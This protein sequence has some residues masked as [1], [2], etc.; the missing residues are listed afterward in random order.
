MMFGRKSLS[1]RSIG[2][3]AIDALW[4]LGYATRFLG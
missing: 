3:H 1:V 2:A 4:R